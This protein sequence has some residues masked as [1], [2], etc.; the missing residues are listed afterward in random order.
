VEELIDLEDSL[1]IIVEVEGCHFACNVRDLRS[2]L[3]AASKE[4]LIF[5]L[6]ISTE[7]IQTVVDSRHVK[8]IK[9]NVFDSIFP[10]YFLKIAQ[11]N[12]KH[13]QFK[14]RLGEFIDQ[15][16]RDLRDNYLNLHLWLFQIFDLLANL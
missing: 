3:K 8:D 4:L 5:N 11:R 10:N 12:I 13:V 2:N 1:E 15:I 9:F 6:L 16:K 7:Y 14:Y